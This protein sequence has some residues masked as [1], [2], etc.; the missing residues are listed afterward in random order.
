MNLPRSAKDPGEVGIGVIGCGNVAQSVHLP[1]LAKMDGVRV[2]AISDR[3]SRRL[4]ESAKIVPEAAMHGDY[5]EL[6]ALRD[7]EAVVVCLPTALHAVAAIA[8]M[9][10]G[11]QIYLEKP[12]ATNARDARRLLKVWRQAGVV[13]MV[14]FNYR[15][16][17]LYQELRGCVESGRIG[18]VVAARSVFTTA[19]GKIPSWKQSGEGSGALLELA[20]HEIDLMRFVLG[21]EVAEVFADSRSMHSEAD[22]VALQLKMESGVAVQVIVALAAVEEARF[23]VTGDRG[24]A[25]VDRYRSLKVAVTGPRVEGVGK[26]FGRALALASRVGYLVKRIRAPWGQPSFETALGHFVGAV[27]DEHPASPDLLDGWRTL[28]VMLAAEESA[29][30]HQ[31][32]E[33]CYAATAEPAAADL[34]DV[35]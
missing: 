12:M 28:A 26:R 24:K 15:F 22:T 29:R 34:G 31:V 6:L 23:E 20:S 33:P 2:V 32:K 21:D 3:D 35:E 1:V 7:V 13:G 27:R 18:R 8:A 25:A 30:G 14:G 17:E 19:A 11:K 4:E 5:D 10:E 16:N 9:Q